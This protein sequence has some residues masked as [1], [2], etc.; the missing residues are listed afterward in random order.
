MDEVADRHGVRMRRLNAFLTTC[1]F[2][3]TSPAFRRPP[4]PC[5]PRWETLPYEGSA[6]HVSLIARRM[7]ALHHIRSTPH[8]CLITSIAALM[9]RLLPV[10]TFISTTL[11]FKLNG[12]IERE[13]L[14]GGLLRLGYR[15]VSV[16]E[17][18]G[19]SVFEAVLWI[20]SRRPM[21]TRCVS[22]SLA[23][24]S[25][26]SDSSIP[27][28]RSPPRSWIVPSSFPHANTCVRKR[29]RTPLPHSCRR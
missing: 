6:P 21:P 15:K 14:T 20:Y 7:N 9:Q 17:I 8:T 13:V 2:S 19:S 11:Q 12:T 29:R 23:K 26:H 28:P 22:S 5:S 27:P 25:I 10:T 24:P 1:I 16:V 3:M 4:S 18:P